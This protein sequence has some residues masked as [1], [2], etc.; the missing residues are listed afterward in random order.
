MIIIVIEPER[1]YKWANRN[2]YRNSRVGSQVLLTETI[3]PERNNGNENNESTSNKTIKRICAKIGLV[4]DGY[5]HWKLE[6]S[7]II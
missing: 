4:L 2:L 6:L 3:G 7:K 1:N 5:A